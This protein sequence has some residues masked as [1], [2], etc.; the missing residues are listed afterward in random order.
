MSTAAALRILDPGR[1]ATIQDDGRFHA[2]QWG[3][4][5][6]GM[7]DPWLYRLALAALFHASG[8]PLAALTPPPPLGPPLTFPLIEHHFGGF[9]F[10]AE[11]A[12]FPVV[13]A[14]N[15]RLRIE[16]TQLTVHGVLS[17]VLAPGETVIVERIGEGRIAVVGAGTL[18]I[19][20][21]LGSTSTELRARFGGWQGRPLAAGDRIPVTPPTQPP[22]AAFLPLPWPLAS[23]EPIRSLPGAQWSAFA[24]D[25]RAAWVSALWQVTPASDR[26]GAR[27]EGPMLVATPPEIRSEPL[28]PGAVQVPPAGQPIVLLNDA[29]T[30]G[31][32]P[33][34]AQVIEADRW[35][36]AHLQPGEEIRF[37]WLTD[38]DNAWHAF[39]ARWRRFQQHAMA[40]ARSAASATPDLAA[41]I[42]A[43][44]EPDPQR[45][46]HENLVS[47]V[48]D[49]TWE[50]FV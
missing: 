11:G 21:C 38:P 32:Y 34:I 29:Q 1:F 36:L 15:V 9:A 20:E 24:D 47:G 42:G 26:M 37:A 35:R 14:G 10:T 49:A 23:T 3:V 4:P 48:W 16:D 13:V 5:R 44:G 2:R 30:M 50:D 45:L 25:A 22:C 41:L 33:K 19:P 8:R 46:W 17:W 6:A 39:S 40:R 12:P 7:L 31:G 28:W 18:A 27:L 43:G